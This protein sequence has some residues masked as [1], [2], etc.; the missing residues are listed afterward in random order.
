MKEDGNIREDNDDLL[1]IVSHKMQQDIS[2]DRM[3]NLYNI[4][5]KRFKEK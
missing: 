3:E 5:V 1:A 2:T 4:V